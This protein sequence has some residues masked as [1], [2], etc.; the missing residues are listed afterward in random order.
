MNILVTGGAGFIGSH[1][2]RHLVKSFP[3]Y[4]ITNLDVL[5]YAADLSRLDDVNNA[6]N[7]QFVK[8]N[9]NDVALVNRLFSTNRIEAVIHLAAESHVDRSIDGPLPFGETNIVGTMNLLNTCRAHWSKGANHR[10]YHIST[11]EVYGSLGKE[12]F[13]NEKSPYR[14][15]SPYAASKAG[16]DHMV[17]AYGETYGLPYV[18]SNCSNN[19]GPDQH[20]E[21]L[22]PNLLSC[23]QQNQPLPIYGDGLNMRDWLYVE[24]HVSAIDMIFH[25][26]RLGETYLVGGRCELSNLDVAKAL[27]LA[28]DRKLSRNLGTAEKLITFVTDRPGHDFRY[29]IDPSKLESTLGWYPKTNWAEGI[30]KTINA[31]LDKL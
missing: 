24:D 8:G 21:K 9:I 27:C 30:E 6:P 28:Y 20:T 22:I 2:I 10:F 3:D 11:D 5:T 18:I 4:S 26:G 31:Y 17:R 16:A 7:Y 19:Y 1:L 29:A 25:R 12:G 23:L 14:P 15:R 13:F